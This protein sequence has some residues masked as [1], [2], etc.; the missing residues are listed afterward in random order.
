MKSSNAL[1]SSPA[2]FKR[3]TLV[4]EKP[5]I[6]GQLVQMP[7]D[8]V[9]QKKSAEIV[10]QEEFTTLV[11]NASQDMAKEMTLQLTLMMPDCSI[12]YSPTIELAK[13]ILTRRKI[14]LVVSSPVL[15]DGS[16]EKLRDTLNGLDSPPDIVVV[17]RAGLQRTS[18]FTTSGYHFAAVK[19]I[20]E[21]EKPGSLTQKTL[22]LTANSALKQAIRDLGSDIRNDLNNPLQ[23]IVAMVF[24]AK[25]G[26]MPAGA[27]DKALLAIE[28]AAQNMAQ[29]VNKLEEKIHTTVT[30]AA[31][32]K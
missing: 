26:T 2:S 8:A 13:W 18:L 14:N 12:M 21:G 24:V 20:S 19:K 17:G 30:S 1:P 25:T 27:T 28:N 23:E 3:K 29:V 11:V 22:S 6:N 7:T 4:L 31:L 16:V 15:P 32:N 10:A 5:G 9:N